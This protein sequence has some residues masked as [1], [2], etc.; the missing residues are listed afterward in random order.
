[1][2]SLAI[3]HRDSAANLAPNFGSVFTRCGTSD[4]DFYAAD[5]GN[6]VLHD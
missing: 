5:T 3:M 6:G 1:M 2:N 4:I